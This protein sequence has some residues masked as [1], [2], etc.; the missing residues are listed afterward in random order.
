MWIIVALLLISILFNIVSVIALRRTMIKTESY[1]I[2]F[3][4]VQNALK[5][6]IHTMKEVDIRGSFEADD[7]VG[8]IFKSMLSLVELL[9]T[10]LIGEVNS[11]DI[12]EITKT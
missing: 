3:I 11:E 5:N 6:I 8:G 9:D 4:E 12:D 1:D 7:E 10:F 2:F